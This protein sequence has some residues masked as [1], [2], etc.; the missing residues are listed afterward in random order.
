MRLRHGLL[1]LP[2]II[3]PP[4]GT[5]AVVASGMLL[6]RS[7]SLLLLDLRLLDLLLVAAA[8]LITHLSALPLL[9]Q[10]LHPGFQLVELATQNTSHSLTFRGKFLHPVIAPVLPSLEKLKSYLLFLHLAPKCVQACPPLIVLLGNQAAQ[11]LL[12]MF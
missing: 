4:R 1:R 3:L 10:L 5:P 7:C 9:L 11:R 2:M 12:Q 6:P 8:P